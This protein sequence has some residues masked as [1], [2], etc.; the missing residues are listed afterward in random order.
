MTQSIRSLA[1]LLLGGAMLFFVAQRITES[2]AFHMP[3]DFPE[4][5]AAGRLNLRGE[6]PYDPERLLKEQRL[7]DPERDEALM[8]W[9]PPPALALYMPFG[10]LPPRLAGLIWVGV[11]LLAVLLACDLLWQQY[12]SRDKRWLSPLVGFLFVGTW[13]LV[14]FGQNSGLILLGLTGFLHFSERRKPAAAG[15]CAALTALKPHLLAGF[16]LLLLVDIV[17]RQGRLTLLA[18]ASVI[19]LSLGVALLLNPNLIEQYLSATRNPGPGAISLRDW[20]LPVLAYWL[21]METVPEWFWIQFAPCLLGCAGLL[22]W[23]IRSGMQWDWAKA[24]PWVVAVS[25]LIAPYG[26]IFDLPVLLVPVIYVASRLFQTRHWVL[27]GL[28]LLGQLI[29]NIVTESIVWP[30]HDL[31]WVAPSVL[32][33]CLLGWPSMKKR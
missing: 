11:Q 31:W 22:I 2:P 17:S 18:G 30:L 4:Y 32:I 20:K 8:M 28:F 25:V 3:K 7:I 33:L 24:L 16:G 12:H 23:R 26:W 14:T 19:A 15:A 21:R 5:W 6:N 9:N 13:W 27:L 10:L 1:V 29:V